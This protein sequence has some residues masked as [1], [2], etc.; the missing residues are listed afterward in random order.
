MAGGTNDRFPNEFGVPTY[1]CTRVWICQLQVTCSA[2][3]LIIRSKVLLVA[4]S[5][6]AY[7][8]NNQLTTW[9]TANLFYD[10]NGNMTS[11]GMHNYTW[12]ARNRLSQIDLGNT[13]TFTYD[14]FGRRISKIVLGVQT[15]FL[16]DRANPVQELSGTTPT[17]NFITGKLDEYFTRT[18]SAGARH[19]LTDALGST[20]ALADSTGTV[21]TS[22]TF[23]PF[24]NAT[25]G[26][27]ATTNTFTYTGRELDATSLYFYRTRYYNPQLQRFISEDPIGLNGGDI[28]IYAHTR[29]SPT[30]HTDAS[31][32]MIDLNSLGDAIGNFALNHANY[33]PAVCSADSFRFYG[34]GLESD[35]GISGGAFRLDDVHYSN[36]PDGWHVDGLDSSQLYEVGGD[37]IGGGVVMKGRKPEEGLVFLPLLEEGGNFGLAKGEAEL[38]LLLGYS[39]NGLA[40]GFYGDG[41]GGGGPFR[42]GGGGGWAVNFT[43]AATCLQQMR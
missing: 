2:K 36:G 26:G 3:S 34:G 5:Q 35:S 28:N 11:D 32:K 21:Q 24:G 33:I 19:F 43:S 14:P 31:G 22:Y 30:N 10:L 15:G 16:Y 42:V 41:L 38:D 25:V 37:R 20:L 6:T 17:A 18:D 12:D 39:N 1:A 4:M 8:S 23:E 29:N 9:G 40:M 27:A 7:N 13:A